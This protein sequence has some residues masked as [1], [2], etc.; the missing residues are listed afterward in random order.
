[1]K[2]SSLVAGLAAILALSTGAH[3]ECSLRT[4]AQFPVT[5]IDQR[6]VVVGRLDGRRVK[7]LISGDYDFSAL[8]PDALT[9]FGLETSTAPVRELA[10]DRP[11]VAGSLEAGRSTYG[12]GFTLLDTGVFGNL[13]GVL[14]ANALN[15]YDTEYDLGGGVVRVIRS[16]DCPTRELAYW[17]KDKPYAALTMAPYDAAR[18]R[19][20]VYLTLNGMRVTALIDAGQPRSAITRQ[21]AVRANLSLDDSGGWTYANSPDLKLDQEEVRP[22][23]MRVIE[24]PATEYDIVLGADFLAAHRVYVAR[25]QHKVY[26]TY[27]G[28]AVFAA[29]DNTPR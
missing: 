22:P 24:R 10:E 9:R 8:K 7:L 27:N 15:T 23:R 21:A 6:P 17:N 14:G 16:R 25:R 11:Y 5:L 12:L 28:G 3:A 1:M 13:D 20:L 26:V 19:D 18:P 4:L 2:T 29:A